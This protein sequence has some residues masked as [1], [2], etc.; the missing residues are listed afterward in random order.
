MPRAWSTRICLI[1]LAAIGW[2]D[3]DLD[4]E[5]ADAIVR[6]AIEEGIELE[7]IE[8][9]EAATKEPIDIGKIDLSNTNPPYGHLLVSFV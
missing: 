7:E 9:I 1:A 3:G 4:G 5:E 6:T 2:A 8:E